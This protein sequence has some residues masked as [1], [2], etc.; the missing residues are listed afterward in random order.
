MV[1]KFILIEKNK[2]KLKNIVKT[3]NIVKPIG[4]SS[5]AQEIGNYKKILNDVDILIGAIS[6]LPVITKKDV[7]KFKKKILF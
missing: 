6:G 4:T 1:Q 3:I 2:K 7:I 5:T